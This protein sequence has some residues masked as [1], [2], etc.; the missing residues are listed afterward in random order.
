MLCYLSLFG[1]PEIRHVIVRWRAIYATKVAYG[2]AYT[3]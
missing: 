1:G 2:Q 3:S